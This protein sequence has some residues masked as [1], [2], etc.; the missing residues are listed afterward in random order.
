[1]T[2][3]FGE[4]EYNE[5]VEL[6]FSECLLRP[7]EQEPSVASWGFEYLGGLFTFHVDRLLASNES[8][9]NLGS[10]VPDEYRNLDGINF[11]QAAMN[12]G[13]DKQTAE[14]LRLL[15]ILSGVV[16]HGKIIH[17]H[18]YVWGIAPAEE[19]Q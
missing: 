4:P 7:G 15:W 2:L 10:L 1:M 12:L 16:G 18:H 13:A 5:M 9:I 6:V 11:Q 17:T 14:T 19:K 8:I 3:V